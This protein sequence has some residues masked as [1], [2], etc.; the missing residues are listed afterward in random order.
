MPKCRD[1]QS[2]CAQRARTAQAPRVLGDKDGE[3]GPL[4]GPPRAPGGC[5]GLNRRGLGRVF[6]PG[7][8]RTDVRCDTEPMACGAP[9]G[10][11][12]TGGVPAGGET[13]VTAAPALGHEA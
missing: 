5:W 3:L 13:Q 7:L 11:G 9:T 12:E 8:M 2:A 1:A 10:G 6:S 4:E